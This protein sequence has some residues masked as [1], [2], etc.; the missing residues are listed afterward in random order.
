MLSGFG[1]ALN[2]RKTLCV[3]VSKGQMQN[4]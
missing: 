2:S 1:Y 3:E 4:L